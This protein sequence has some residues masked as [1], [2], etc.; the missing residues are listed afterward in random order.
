MPTSTA[1]S[2]E[3][4]RRFGRLLPAAADPVRAPA[5]RAYLRDQFDFLGIASPRLTVLSREALA[6]LDPPDEADLTA[7]ALACWAEPA[8]EYQYVACAYL[9][10]YVTVCSPGFV[11][12]ARRLVVTK[13]WWDTVDTLASHSVG[14]LVA[15]HPSLRSTMDE[16][17][18]DENLW[19]ARTAILHQL[20][21]KVDTDVE[22]L[23]RYC[24]FRAG[25]PDFFIRKAIGWAL[26]E[27]AKTD[28]AAVRGFVRANETLLSG[29]SRREAL[30]NVALTTDD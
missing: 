21:Y 22:R 11:S 24:K 5:A 25:H 19:V 15:R 29:L 28:P 6:G 14:G 9:R 16:W 8:R 26:R 13:S 2:A 10:R 7:F 27:Y 17:V 20:R 12:T 23:F 4:L 3:L 18:A 1:L 30:K